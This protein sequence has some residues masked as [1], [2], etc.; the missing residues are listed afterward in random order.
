MRLRQKLTVAFFGVS[1]LLSLLLALF[2]YR[3]V[4]RQLQEDLRDRLRDITHIGT[5]VIDL[6]AYGKLRELLPASGELS[7]SAYSDV[8]HSP[9]YRRV[10]DQLRAIRSADRR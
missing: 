6:D 9:Q 2:L 3:F 10:Y 4:E 5:H 7:E 1:S 8:E